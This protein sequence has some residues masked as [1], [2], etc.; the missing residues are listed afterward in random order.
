MA[1]KRVLFCAESV[2]QLFNAVTLRMTVCADS[3]CDL[4]LSNLTVWEEDMIAR[5]ENSG[6]FGMVLRP[7]TR[8]TERR[9]WDTDDKSRYRAV[10]D[11]SLFF[12]GGKP[13]IDPVYEELFCP[14]DHIYWKMLYH[15]H[16]TNGKMPK[17][18]MYDEG[19]RAYTMNLPATD[20]KP[21]LTGK[22]ANATFVS[23][24]EA[25]YLYQPD[26]YA[27]DT[28]SYELRKLPNPAQYPEIR[29]KLIEIYGYEKMPD[30]P[31]IYLEDFFFADRFNTNDFL[32]FEQVAKAVG[33]ENIIV[34]R[35]PR[36]AFDRFEPLGYKTVTR[37]VVPWEIQLLAND[38]R[39]KVLISVSSTSILTP[40]IIFDSDMHVISLEKMFRGENRTHADAGFK[41]FFNGLKNKIN[42]NAVHFHSPA[43]F[44]EFTE[45]LR[46]IRLTQRSAND[47]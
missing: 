17:I 16:V 10:E 8:E 22:Y 41:K 28:Y 45:V 30:E 29:E 46:Y 2:Y 25:Y 42:E 26:L 34:K 27:V 23:A 18:F 43:S 6:V 4:I 13:P 11:L 32:L 40:Y 38:L 3:A 14:I 9:F 5:L 44:E 19:V 47:V 31:Y 24:I 21:Y 37:S 7:L 20:N 15:Y 12:D 1:A 35:H 33:K 36:D 39:S